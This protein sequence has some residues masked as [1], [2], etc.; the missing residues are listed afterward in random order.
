[1]YYTCFLKFLARSV[2]NFFFY[3]H[4]TEGRRYFETG[5]NGQILYK[6]YKFGPLTRFFRDYVAVFWEITPKF[7]LNTFL[8]I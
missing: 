4:F 3:G 5:Q 6:I 1:M 7:F 2:N 8:G